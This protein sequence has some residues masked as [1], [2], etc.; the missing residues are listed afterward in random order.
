MIRFDDYVRDLTGTMQRIYAACMEGPVPDHIPREHP[1]RRRHAY[2][3][4]RSLAQVGIDA[5]ALNRRLAD[6][7]AWCAPRTHLER[8]RQGDSA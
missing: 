8:D 5:V 7:R 1:P 2:S 6:Y 3:L 4:D